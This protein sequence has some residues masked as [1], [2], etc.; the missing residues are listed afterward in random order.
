MGSVVPNADFIAFGTRALV[1]IPCRLALRHVETCTNPIAV[2]ATREANGDGF[3]IRFA[4]SALRGRSTINGFLDTN[5]NK[6]F[7]RNSLAKCS[8]TEIC[9]WKK[10]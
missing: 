5:V 1:T 3:R 9:L 7:A 2:A 4:N 6:C 8:L 10:F